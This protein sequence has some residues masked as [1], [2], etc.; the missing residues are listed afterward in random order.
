MSD[1]QQRLMADAIMEESLACA[2]PRMPGRWRGSEGESDDFDLLE[3]PLS[4]PDRPEW[5]NMLA[6]EQALMH[7]TLV[8]DHFLPPAL[9]AGSQRCAMLQYLRKPACF[10][11]TRFCYSLSFA[12]ISVQLFAGS[13]FPQDNQQG[14]DDKV[15]D[16]RESLLLT[17]SEVQVQH[18]NFHR[19]NC[20]T[21]TTICK[22]HK[23]AHKCN[24]ALER[25]VLL[26]RSVE[27]DDLLATSDVR[28][29]LH[30]YCSDDSPLRT[31]AP[32]LC[33]K[34]LHVDADSTESNLLNCTSATDDSYI[35]KISALPI[36]INLH[37]RTLYFCLEIAQRLTQLAEQ[38]ANTVINELGL[39]NSE[40]E[41]RTSNET[42]VQNGAYFK[43]VI[44]ERDMLVVLDYVGGQF[45]M[46][47]VALAAVVGSLTQL[48]DCRFVL[49]RVVHRRGL[50][51]LRSVLQ[52]L[53]T[54]WYQDLSAK[55]LV[56]SFEPVSFA[57]RLL[58]GLF[59]LF[60]EPL[61]Q[62]RQ[63]RS[64]L[65][66]VKRGC[67]SFTQSTGVAALELLC[68]FVQCLE[69]LARAAHEIVS[70]RDPRARR[71]R[72][73]TL[74]DEMHV[75][76][77]ETLRY[78]E[79][80]RRSEG[81]PEE[82]MFANYDDRMCELKPLSS[83]R[84]R[85][86]SRPANSVGSLVANVTQVPAAVTQQA[87]HAADNLQLLVQGIA[88]HIDPLRKEREDMKWKPNV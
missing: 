31:H 15:R 38:Q 35:L 66:G 16:D 41:T 25:N 23:S 80:F 46:Q 3:K 64:V 4:V 62:F 52:L 51:G 26:V 58:R 68:R 55:K 67:R 20:D 70:P 45:D 7:V 69:W 53:A 47:Y 11:P 86:Q 78:D 71:R 2:R 75:V 59:D 5:Q 42:E 50:L 37:Q 22:L 18:E 39:S 36:R 29:L 73:H 43:T 54:S 82:L 9:T 79:A 56:A 28:K 14:I 77:T 27:L 10:P 85:L 60:Y 83:R 48:R 6:D 87:A 17:F 13:D 8:H 33:V 19:T 84:P 40:S 32:V 72:L 76:D 74:L 34:L 81:L 49:K 63:N 65:T 24:M 12:K 30:A 88:N 1:A 44:F 21:V 57:V 61:H